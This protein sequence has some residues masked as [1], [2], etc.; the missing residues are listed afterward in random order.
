MTT[1]PLI[2]TLSS[3]VFTF[4][5]KLQTIYL[6]TQYRHYIHIKTIPSFKLNLTIS[7]SQ[8]CNHFITF[9]SILRNYIGHWSNLLLNSLANYTCDH[10]TPEVASCFSNPKNSKLTPSLLL[11]ITTL[12]P[13][14]PLNTDSSPICHFDTVQKYNLY[15]YLVW[16]IDGD[17]HIM[18]LELL[19]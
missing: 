11:Q 2:S 16:S 10:H 9:S 14:S 3:S 18:Y 4:K 12:V 7:P 15:T 19:T 6:L 8:H 5:L 13:Y 17:L 1:H